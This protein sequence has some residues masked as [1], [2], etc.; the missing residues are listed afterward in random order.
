LKQ[1]ATAPLV[2]RAVLPV[3]ITNRS[4][5]TGTV[6]RNLNFLICVWLATSVNVYSLDRDK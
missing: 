4:N 2:R 1:L 5:H 3:A 6:E